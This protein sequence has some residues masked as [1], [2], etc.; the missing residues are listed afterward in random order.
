MEQAL[1]LIEF[2][3]VAR[4]DEVSTDLE[5]ARLTDHLHLLIAHRARRT[6]R[7]RGLPRGGFALA[8]LALV[9]LDLERG[10]DGELVVE[11]D[12]APLLPREAPLDLQRPQ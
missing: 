2:T 7:V 4:S 1:D 6:C 9:Q 10:G 11:I 3:G 12:G 8:A 5:R